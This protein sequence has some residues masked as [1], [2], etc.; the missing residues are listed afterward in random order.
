MS[1]PGFLDQRPKNDLLKRQILI[2]E[3]TQARMVREAILNVPG[4]VARLQ[5]LDNQ[6]AAVRAQLTPGV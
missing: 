3:R 2:L 5:A 4:A 1:D 6:I